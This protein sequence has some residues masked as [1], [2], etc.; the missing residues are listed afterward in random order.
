MPI[1]EERKKY[2]YLYRKEHLRRVTLD[3]PPEMYE[4]V[5]EAATK[6]EMPV[7]TFIKWLLDQYIKHPHNQ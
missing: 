1:S 3:M 5:K 6:K 4:K 7:N 2:L